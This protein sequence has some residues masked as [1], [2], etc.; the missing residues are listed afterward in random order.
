[1]G[2]VSHAKSKKKGEM[3]DTITMCIRLP[4]SL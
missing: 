2:D 1:M 3:K 4:V